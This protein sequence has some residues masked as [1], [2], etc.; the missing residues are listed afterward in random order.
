MQKIVEGLKKYRKKI[1]D[2]FPKEFLKYCRIIS[3][4]ISHDFKIKDYDV[5]P[6]IFAKDGIS[7]DI[8]VIY[9]ISFYSREVC[10]VWKTNQIFECILCG[11]N[12]NK[13]YRN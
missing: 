12:R 5:I 4:G 8:S 10:D 11:P 6:K 9:D 2:M 3:E 13:N 7:K 1:E